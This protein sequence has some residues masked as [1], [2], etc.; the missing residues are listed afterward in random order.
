MGWRMRSLAFWS[1]PARIAAL[2]ALLGLS[3]CSANLDKPVN[4]ANLQSPVD[5]AVSAN[6]R[7]GPVSVQL[8]GQPQALNWTYDPSGQKQSATLTA[9][10]GSHML[11]VS[12][13]HSCWY[14]QGGN[15]V[16]QVTR[17]FTVAPPPSSVD[18]DV[19][20][21]TIDV[22]RGG[23]AQANLTLTRHNASGAVTI[24]ASNLPTG[25]T[26]STTSIG[27]G[28]NSGGGT[29]NA[30]SLASGS[31]MATFTTS[32][33]G[34]DDKATVR[35]VP[36][37]GPFSFIQP[38]TVAG[39]TST[40]TDPGGSGMSAVSTQQG[41]TRISTVDFKSGGQV[42][43]STQF[44][45]WAGAGGSN[46]GG[47]KF[48]PSTSGSAGITAIVY[49]DI[50]ETQSP[51]PGRTNYD[52][53]VK[54]IHFD[55]PTSQVRTGSI[56]SRYQYGVLPR[57]GFS[58]DCSIIA[59][60]RAGFMIDRAFDFANALAGGSSLFGWTYSD[61]ATGFTGGASIMGAVITVTG[62]GNQ[63]TTHATP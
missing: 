38:P 53:Q 3:A 59:S 23:M 33:G 58:A 51:P 43:Y 47:V 22:P 25:V 28:V 11:D 13:Q 2:A 60:W 1:T 9:P 21:S 50:D 41:F 57:I 12:I 49:S 37:A 35:V 63:S 40:E 7:L 17:M 8:D 24:T 10:P 36:K 4:N 29:L 44:A 46:L 19:M 52:Y 32:T 42:R 61:T 18:V 56:P 31:K 45:T 39:A 27:A 48:C 15:N 20:P 6:S 34:V 14:C 62:S 54:I 26:L 16:T 30:T 55:T 5:V